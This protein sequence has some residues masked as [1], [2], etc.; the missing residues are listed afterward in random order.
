MRNSQVVFLAVKPHII[1]MVLKEV[2][3]DITP[4]HLIISLA[5]GT[6][7]KTMEEVGTAQ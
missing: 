7:L 5:A 2:T 3:A 6:K 4:D 1:S